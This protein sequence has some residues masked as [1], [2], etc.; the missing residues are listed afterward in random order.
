MAQFTLQS[1]KQGDVCIIRTQGYLNDEAGRAI[2]AAC[3]PAA[4]QGTVRF[5]LNFAES[6]VINSPGITELLELSEWLVYERKARLVFVGL[7]DLHKNVFK[8]VGL[9]KLAAVHETEE[10]ALAAF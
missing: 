8:V 5:V 7:K 2:R 3:E 9:L 6:P 4:T 1:A 10:A